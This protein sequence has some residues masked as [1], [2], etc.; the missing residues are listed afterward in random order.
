MDVVPKWG[1]FGSLPKY[2]ISASHLQQHAARACL[3]DNGVRPRYLQH[4]PSCDQGWDFALTIPSKSFMQSTHTHTYYTH[5]H[6]VLSELMYGLGTV[7]PDWFAFLTVG[8]TNAPSGP[9]PRW[10]QRHPEIPDQTTL[11]FLV[12]YGSLLYI[13]QGSSHFLRFSLSPT[14]VS[15]LSL[16]LTTTWGEFTEKIHSKLRE[17][18][19]IFILFLLHFA[20]ASFRQCR[21]DL[22]SFFVFSFFLCF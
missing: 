22:S 20:D 9:E 15:H 5:T 16:Q 11:S 6:L 14:P 3:D 8:G 7:N 19:A 17:Q 1:L 4:S 12:L 10:G 2:W 18:D 21:P 13:Q